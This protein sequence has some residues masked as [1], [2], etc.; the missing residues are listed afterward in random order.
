M[1]QT[2]PCNINITL[3]HLLHCVLLCCNS[4]PSLCDLA[5][6]LSFTS[7]RLFIIYHFMF[8][9]NWPSG[10]QVVGLKEPATL[11]FALFCS[12]VLDVNAL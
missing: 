2:T 5:D 11:L 4:L 7:R 10:V 9:P 12:S 1:A 3:Q 8:R 6:I